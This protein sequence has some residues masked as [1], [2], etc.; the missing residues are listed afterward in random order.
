MSPSLNMDS[1]DTGHIRS[2]NLNTL[3]TL[4]HVDHYRNLLSAGNFNMKK[5]PTLL[6]LHEMQEDYEGDI[7]GALS[8]EKQ[9]QIK[10]L[11]GEAVATGGK[12]DPKP[13]K[14]GWI[15]GVLIRCLLNIW[16]VMLFLRLSWVVGQAGIGLSVLVVCLSC[17]VTILTTLSMSAICTNGQVKGGGAYYLISR[18]LGPEFGGA[19]GLIFSVANAVA[20]AMYIVGFAETIRDMLKDNDALMIDEINDVRIIG[21]IT[22][23]FLLAI[24]LIGMEWEARAQVVLLAILLVAMINIIIGSFIPPNDDKQA[25]GFLGYSSGVIK[26]N[27][28]PDFRNNENFFSVF[29]IFFPAATGILAGANISGDL[30]DAQKAIPKGTLVAILVSSISYIGMAVLAG[31]S[32]ERDAIG[33]LNITE[34]ST[35]YCQEF[36]CK[37]GLQNDMQAM[38]LISAFGPLVTA[39]IFAAT[40]SS[41]LASLVSAPKVFQAVCKDKI[42]PYISIFG[43]GY[44]KSDEPRLGY[45]LTFFI[46]AGFIG[47]GHLNAIAPLISNFFLMSYALINYSCFDASFAKSPGWRPAFKYYNMWLALFG[48]ILCL[49]VMFIINWWT[50]LITFFLNISLYAYVHYKKP[51]I[52]WGS[53]TQAHVYKNALNS[54]LKLVSVSEHIKNYRPQVIVLA[55]HPLCRPDLVKFAATITKDISLFICADIILNEKNLTID[56]TRGELAYKW[57]SKNKIKAFYNSI[58]SNSFQNGVTAALQTSGLGK[59]K[60]NTLLLGFKRNWVKSSQFDV[61]EYVSIIHNAFDLRYGVGILRI[62]EGFCCQSNAIHFEEENSDDEKSPQLEKKELKEQ[63]PESRNNPKPDFPYHLHTDRRMSCRPLIKA[64]KKHGTIDVWWLFDDG[65]LTLLIPYLLSGHWRNSKLRV[66]GASS[67]KGELDRDQRSMATLLSKFRIDCASIKMISD[68]GRKPSIDGIDRFDDLVAPW[69]LGKDESPVENPWKVSEIVLSAQ[70]DRTY[71]HIRLRE[72][73]QEHSCNA[74]LIV[75]TLP[76]PRKS[77]VPSGLYMCWLETITKG[78]PP[79]LLLRGNQ[80]SVLTF[81]S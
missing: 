7:E 27:F 14:F 8:D 42:F 12:H 45:I 39:G 70:K 40:L 51:D 9:M 63:S 71:R 77:I 13:L 34:N 52:N 81:Y 47:I 53:S 41:A 56:H 26:E 16:G 10:A 60:P 23:C 61:H 75:M 76:M 48:A 55:G 62:D 20:V 73:L 58:K 15:K 18:S 31:A 32:V 2:A 21:L 17:V 29:A 38:R 74:N 36:T 44:G 43:K 66:F 5:R 49:A 30:K 78:M 68:I 64:S 46:A 50:A 28:K 67:K 6:E 4:P 35:N 69:I 11:N 33:N 1:Y 65:G 19:I 59:L 80:E 25:K 79:I 72:I 57:F 24:A 54:T 22:V 37:F 3:E